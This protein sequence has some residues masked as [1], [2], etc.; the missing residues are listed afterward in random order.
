MQNKVVINRGDADIRVAFLE[1]NQLVEFHQEPFNQKSLVGNIYRG[2]IQDVIPGLQAA[3]VDIGLERNVFLHF[4]DV[5][6]ESLVMTESNLEEALQRASET[7]IPGRIV[8]KGRRDRVDLKAGI[9]EAPIAKGD[10][11]IVQVVKD[12]IGDKAPRVTTNLALAGRYVVLLPFPGQ[13]GGVSRKVAMGK[14]RFALK[15]M[16]N[17]LRSKSQSF[18]MRTAGLGAA[19]EQVNADVERLQDVWDEITR[20]FRSTKKPKLVYSDHNIVDRMVRDVFNADIDE[21]IL[22]DAILASELKESLQI[23]MPKLANVVEVYNGNEPI[24]EAFSIERQLDLALDNKYWLK[25]G[26]YLI[27]EE[28]EALTAID[29]N[30]GR[31]TGSKDQERTSFKI[32]M[33]ACEAIA[34][35]IRLRDIGGIIVIDFIDMLNTGN[36]RKVT[37]EFHQCM[38]FD[39]AKTQIGQV[40]EFGLLMLTRKRKNKSLKKQIFEDCPYCEGKAHVLRKEEI[41][42]RIKSDLLLMCEDAVKLSAIV[43]TCEPAL[44]EFLETT[45]KSFVR[46]ISQS[47]QLDIIIRPEATLHREDFTLTGIER[48]GRDALLLPGQRLDGRRTFNDTL[49][50]DSISTQEIVESIADWEE[51]GAIEEVDPAVEEDDSLPKRTRRG[52]RGGRRRQPLEDDVESSEDLPIGLEAIDEDLG[53]IQEVAALDEELEAEA[54]KLAT[55]SSVKQNG[56]PYAESASKPYHKH[57]QKPDHKQEQKSGAWGATKP[58]ASSVAPVVPGVDAP[59]KSKLQVV[60][61]NSLIVPKGA[62]GGSDDR[63]KAIEAAVKQPSNRSLE[64]LKT[65]KILSSFDKRLPKPEVAAEVAV[66]K[67]AAAAT[68]AVEA[69]PALTTPFK[70]SRNLQVV[71]RWGAKKEQPLA[72]KPAVAPPSATKP[73]AEAKPTEAKATAPVDATA[74]AETKPTAKRS[75]S[76]KSTAAK[77]ATTTAKAPEAKTE[78]AEDAKPNDKPA[79]PKKT[80][81]KRPAAKKTAT[82]ATGTA[83]KAAA[84]KASEPESRTSAAK[85]PPKPAGKSA[86]AEPATTAKKAATD[87]TTPDDTADDKPA[88]KTTPSRARKPAKKADSAE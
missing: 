38:E 53:E 45:Y 69:K 13:S 25:S 87:A 36:K 14:E 74:N 48:P 70:P 42:R 43:V 78:S 7:I 75:R 85:T 33:E 47:N 83:A 2:V 19:E 55:E 72:E 52:R 1:D 50:Y 80:A 10:T 62:A 3:F 20:S 46:K 9:T 86:K 77:P 21:I 66:E 73:A 65:V 79:T 34:D 22:D 18:I 61:R 51:P 57:E 15:K 64:T 28:T 63:V 37:D 35:Q 71:A 11:I 76:R 27:I 60:S 23:Y 31:F 54:E 32:N 39:R 68:P 59:F 49:P 30:T 26:G 40:G 5:R 12:G 67:P 4:L 44:A 88:K 16:L 56:N 58:A 82:K 17:K 29:V 24:F 81:T 6:A 41:W 8:K 84:D